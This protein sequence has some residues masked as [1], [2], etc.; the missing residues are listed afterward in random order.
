MDDD[1]VCECAFCAGHCYDEDGELVRCNTCG[2]VQ[3]KNMQI[4]QD[5]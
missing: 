3:R 1:I 4:E 5:E 2:K